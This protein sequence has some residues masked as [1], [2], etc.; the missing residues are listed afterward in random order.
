M[1]CTS[2]F[3]KDEIHSTRVLAVT[4]ASTLVIEALLT[5]NCKVATFTQFCHGVFKNQQLC[6]DRSLWSFPGTTLLQF[7]K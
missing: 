3:L 7:L 6:Y 2:K 4:E 5:Q 1:Y